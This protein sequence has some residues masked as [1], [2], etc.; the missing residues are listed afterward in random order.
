MNPKLNKIRLDKIK[1]LGFKEE[2][3]VIDEDDEEEGQMDQ[4]LGT[5]RIPKNLRLLSERLPKSNYG[6]KSRKEDSSQMQSFTDASIKNVEGS[7]DGQ[8][9]NSNQQLESIL[10]ETAEKSNQKSGGV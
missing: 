2:K 7:V 3:V 6:S 5:I 1:D 10:E 8:N 4:L 9:M